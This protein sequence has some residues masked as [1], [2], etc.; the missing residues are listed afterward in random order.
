MGMTQLLGSPSV[1]SF[2]V[3]CR[4]ARIVT[5]RLLAPLLGIGHPVASRPFLLGG[6]S[7]GL[8]VLDGS[9]STTSGSTGLDVA[10][11]ILAFLRLDGLKVLG[12]IGSH[13]GT[14]VVALFLVPPPVVL[15]EAIPTTPVPLIGGLIGEV[16]L[17][18]GLHFSAVATPSLA[19]RVAR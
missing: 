17:R 2:Q 12:P 10:P 18:Q 3:R 5:T 13:Y 14:D 15:P 1:L 4:V 7:L 19:I 11:V 9:M 6:L 8:G 16:E